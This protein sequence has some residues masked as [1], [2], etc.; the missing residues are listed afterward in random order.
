MSPKLKFLLGLI[1]IVAG[2]ATILSQGEHRHEFQ[3]AETWENVQIEQENI[4]NAWDFVI[5]SPDR[6]GVK[7]AY[8][9]R[10][11]FSIVFDGVYDR[12]ARMDILI[13]EHGEGKSNAVRYVVH[14]RSL[15]Q[16]LHG[17]K[18]KNLNF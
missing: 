15:E 11:D 8:S 17:D 16:I 2:F 3:L 1:A 4:N 10:V 18:W 13:C 6:G 9:K 12:E 7:L 14:A 5:S